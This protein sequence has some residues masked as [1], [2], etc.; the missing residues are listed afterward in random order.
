MVHKTT[1]QPNTN[2]VRVSFAVDPN[3]IQI[4]PKVAKNDPDMNRK[5]G[6]S[7]PE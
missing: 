7:I 5:A 4:N 1:A 3:Q 2:V 6:N